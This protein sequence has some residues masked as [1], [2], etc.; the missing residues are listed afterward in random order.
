MREQAGTAPGRGLS[1]F[2][3]SYLLMLFSV[4]ILVHGLQPE[5]DRSG[6][7]SRSP[8]HQERQKTSR[9][10]IPPQADGKLRQPVDDGTPAASDGV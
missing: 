8:V 6:S 10:A 7:S 2:L 4:L 9:Q 3:I 1:W 5:G